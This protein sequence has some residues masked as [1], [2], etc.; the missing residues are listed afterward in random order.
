MWVLLLSTSCLFKFCEN[1][2]IE[3][4]V[5]T[6]RKYALTT[7]SAQSYEKCQYHKRIEDK[8]T[9]EITPNFCKCIQ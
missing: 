2:R 7:E 6:P 3:V 9:F 5:V 4:N 1:L 8:I